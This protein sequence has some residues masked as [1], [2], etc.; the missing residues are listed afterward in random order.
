LGQAP[1]IDPDAAALANYTSPNTGQDAATIG[2]LP[3]DPDMLRLRGELAKDEEIHRM[4]GWTTRKDYPLLVGI[5]LPINDQSLDGAHEAQ[6]WEETNENW[7][8]EANH[9]A[10]TYQWLINRFASRSVH[11]LLPTGMPE[12]I[13]TLSVAV[14][15]DGE[16]GYILVN[17]LSFT[18]RTLFNWT[19]S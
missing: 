2:D 4:I 8:F 14:W 15:K 12:T 3:P 7:I 16:A 6:L 18:R 19:R 17:E 9:A 11:Q 5:S 10:Q 1:T 13:S